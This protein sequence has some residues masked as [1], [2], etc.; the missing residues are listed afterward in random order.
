MREE[1]ES[2]EGSGIGTA[3][4]SADAWFRVQEGVNAVELDVSM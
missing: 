1:K 2:R 4:R 3:E